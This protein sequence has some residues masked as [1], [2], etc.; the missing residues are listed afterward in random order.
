MR[1]LLT[2]AI[3]L[4]VI[5]GGRASAGPSAAPQA[6]YVLTKGGQAITATP[7]QA[8]Q[9][10]EEGWQPETDAQREDREARERAE[11]RDRNRWGWERYALMAVSFVAFGVIAS[12]VYDRRR[13]V[14][15]EVG[16][17]GERK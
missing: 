13:R 2:A 1:S 8:P 12:R 4:V 16:N 9:L 6:V 17:I 5:L 3:A 10:I 15:G 11:A 14:H 7:D